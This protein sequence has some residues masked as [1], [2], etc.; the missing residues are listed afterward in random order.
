[1]SKH[2]S[3]VAE[4]PIQIPVLAL[5][6]SPSLGKLLI[7]LNLKILIAKIAVSASRAMVHTPGWEWM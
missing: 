4:T 3:M 5:V 6:R 2:Y 1:M 7:S